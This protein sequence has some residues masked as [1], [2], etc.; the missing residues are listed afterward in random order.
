LTGFGVTPVPVEPKLFGQKSLFEYDS[1]LIA[2]ADKIVKKIQTEGKWDSVREQVCKFK[3]TTKDK[4]TAEIFI[5]QR[6][7]KLAIF[8]QVKMC[9]N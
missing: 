8:S 7:T 4:A 9:I 6:S 5:D 3:K 1:Q 2:Y